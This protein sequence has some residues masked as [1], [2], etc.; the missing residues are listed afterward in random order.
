MSVPSSVIHILS[1][2]PLNNSYEHSLYFPNKDAQEAYFLGFHREKTFN[3]FTY[4]APERAIKVAGDVANA[5]RWNYLMFQN[6]AGKWY[7]HFITKVEYTNDSAV[8]LY[9]ELDVLQ[10]YMFDWRM[11]Q[12]FIERTHTAT[13]GIGENTVDEGLETGELIDGAVVDKMFDNLV[14]MILTA[15]SEDQKSAWSKIYDG[16][17]SGLAIYAVEI[18]NYAKL[19]TWL[20]QLSNDGTISAIVSMW[21]YPKE[22][23]NVT[24]SWTDGKWL[25]PVSGQSTI[26]Y[27]AAVDYSHEID[28][29]TPKNNKLYCYPYSMVYITNN[30]GGAATFHKERFTGT[31]NKYKF[32]LLGALAPDAGVQLVPQGYNGRSSA[33]DHAL[34]LGAFPT[35]AWDSDTYKVWLAQNQHTNTNTI[36]QANIQAAV[37]IGTGIAGAIASAAS[38]GAGIGNSLLAGGA[39]VLNSYNTVQ[40]LMAQKKDMAVQPPQACGN[41]S[42]NINLAHKRFG[43]SIHF[44][45]VTGEYAGQIDNYFSR[46]GYKVNRVE[47]PSLRNRERFT[48]VKTQGCFVTGELGAEDQ[49]KIQA[50]FDKGVTWWSDHSSV[51]DFTDDNPCI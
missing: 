43:F 27:D 22:L 15:V 51:G 6:D 33:Y 30:L 10:T 23:V 35:C 41:H 47:V 48:Y 12:C 37:G 50:I 21:M 14:I 7:Y 26:E 2:V 8:K 1:G 4:L 42:G 13:D 17:F 32:K 39:A 46:Y 20:D 31:D 9:L 18:S 11:H 5:R 19:G 3:K 45:T 16:V 49:L 38:G 29:Y 28:G 25:H 36:R 34:S 40:S 44:K 24:G